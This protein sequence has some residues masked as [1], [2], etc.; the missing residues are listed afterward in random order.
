M[1]FVLLTFISCLTLFCFIFLG[2]GKFGLLPSYSAYSA[3]WDTVYPIQN[4]NLWSILTFVAAVF[5]IPV[6]LE[7]SDGSMLQFLGFFTPLYLICVSF[8]PNWASN[9]KEYKYH[10]AF[11]FLCALCAF[12][13]IIFVLGKW[14]CILGSIIIVLIS[15][16]LSKTLKSS[17]VFWLEMIMF[18]GMYLA[19]II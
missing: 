11:A 9:P 13:F 18:L 10:V 2:I 4:M 17:L 1:N 14:G 8:T 12:I 7:Y 3:K 15:S 6:L 5:L 16:L 19:L